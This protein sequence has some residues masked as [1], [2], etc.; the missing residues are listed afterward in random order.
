MLAA[1]SVS[2]TTGIGIAI[3]YE[4]TVATPR[5]TGYVG[6][7]R[8]W[9]NGVNQILALLL[10]QCAHLI[11]CALV[12]KLV[13][14]ALDFAELRSFLSGKNLSGRVCDGFS[15]VASLS[16][17]LIS[18]RRETALL[19]DRN[20]VDCVLQC[21][22]LL[23]YR[24]AVFAAAITQFAQN[25]GITALHGCDNVTLAKTEGIAELTHLGRQ[26]ADGTLERIDIAVYGR[27][28]L[29]D[30]S[31][32]ALNSGH[33]KFTTRIV[34]HE[35]A[36]VCETLCGA[37]TT[38]T[39]AEAVPETA[40]SEDEKNDNPLCGVTETVTVATVVVHHRSDHIGVESTVLT[41]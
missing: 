14:L 26:I 16:L 33:E 8:A 32:I 39:A 15:D 6:W 3:A 24:K 11:L 36:E 4:L 30:C 25:C 13:D 38:E 37:T 7:R 31:A 41:E 5:V 27:G 18:Y 10:E 12:T 29:R 1:T 19:T 34:V 20:T 40:P 21:V 23:A 28:K 2:T 17:S 22:C 9:T 35:V